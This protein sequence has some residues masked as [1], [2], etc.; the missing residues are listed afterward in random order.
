[1]VSVNSKNDKIKVNVSSA[2]NKSNANAQYPQTY[3]DSMS[4]QWAISDE[5]VNG[6]D[7]SSKHY[8]QEAK[9]N[10]ES[11]DNILTS[12]QEEHE[13][14]NKDVATGR[15]N[16]ANDL[17]TSLANISAKEKS[18]VDTVN[19]AQANAEASIAEKRTNAEN[20]IKQQEE[21]SIGNI[22]S[23]TAT[24][25][26]EIQT[27]GAEQVNLA[28]EQAEISISKTNEIKEISTTTLSNL[29]E[30]Q[31]SVTNSANNASLSEKNAKE[32]ENK[33]S[34]SAS[35]ATASASQALASA[36]TAT[37]N[38]VIATNKAKEASENASSASASSTSA[39]NYAQQ[40]K[41]S[42]ENA[43][44]SA[45]S[46]ST[47]EA[48]ALLYKNSALDSKEKAS[49][50]EKLALN[51]KNSASSSAE[52]ASTK[53]DIATTQANN[54]SKSATNAQTSANNA[55]DYANS[56][57]TSAENAKASQ[58]ACEDILNR[59]G[60]AIKIKG[61]VN[62]LED[63]PATGNLDGDA[64]L[65]GAE[66]L[67]AYPE[68]YWYLNHWEFLGTSNNGGTW[69]TIKGDISEQNDLQSALNAKQNK[70]TFDTTPTANSTKP[71]TSG[72]IKTA[73]DK[74]IDTT[75]ETKY[76]PLLYTKQ[77]I[78]NPTN[79]VAQPYIKLATVTF[80]NTANYDLSQLF[81]LEYQQA[82]TFKAHALVKL[83]ARWGA[84]SYVGQVFEI[85]EDYN[86][87]N[88]NWESILKSLTWAYKFTAK[89][90][91]AGN[92][93][94]GEIWIKIPNITYCAYYLR[95]TECNCYGDYG[96]I[97]VTVTNNP[98]VYI[99]S[100]NQNV[101]SITEGY[102]QV[103]VV[104]KSTYTLK[105]NKAD[106]P[107][108]TSQLINDSNYAT[109]TEAKYTAG[110]GISINNNVIS[111]TQT[112]AEWGNIQGDI[113]SQNDLI[114]LVESIED[115]KAVQNMYTT[116]AVSTDT[117]GYSQ[118]LS[119]KRSTFDKSKFTVVGTPTITDDGV[120]SG[121]S[122]GNKVS[123]PYTIQNTT[124]FTI[125]DS[126]TFPTAI[127]TSKQSVV[128]G[129]AKS[130]S[131]PFLLEYRVISGGVGALL[132]SN[133]ADTHG[134]LQYNL[135]NELPVSPNK[136]YNYT[137]TV[138]GSNITLNIEG[139]VKTANDFYFSPNTSFYVGC[140]R[141][142]NTPFSG[143]IDLSQFSITVDSKEVFSGNKT[144]I[145]TIKADNY[146][147][148]GSPV[149]T[150]DGVASGFSK[151]NKI[152]TDVIQ[153]SNYNNWEILSP[154][155]RVSE[156]SGAKVVLFL[157]R[158]VYYGVRIE[159]SKKVLLIR[160]AS[161]TT[162][163]KDILFLSSF[164]C[165]LNKPY[166]VRIRFTG[167]EYIVD[168]RIVGNDWIEYGRV[169]NSTKIISDLNSCNIGTTGGGDWAFTGSIDLNSFKI[170]VD[171]N[172]VY[173]PC[174]K[175]PY[176]RAGSK[177]K[178]VDV[179]YRDRVQDLYEQEG[180]A[181]YYTIDEEN[182]N[183]TLPMG[184]I[185]GMI[186]QAKSSADG[187]VSKSGDTM[188]GQLKIKCTPIKDGTTPIVLY[189][190]KASDFGNTTYSNITFKNFADETVGLIG[191]VEHP[192]GSHRIRLLRKDG[193]NWVEMPQI[194][195]PYRNGKSGY[196]LYSNG[197]CEQWGYINGSGGG[198]TWYSF[199][200]PFADD[201]FNIDYTIATTEGH[202]RYT[203][204]MSLRAWNNTGFNGANVGGFGAYWCAR[205]YIT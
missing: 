9:K 47:S 123:I 50:S 134:M 153:L 8:A 205:G 108:K 96:Q 85:L 82:S 161:S 120:A 177:N 13:A 33:A 186:E 135:V 173:Q 34:T 45:T 152:K 77:S 124:N 94:T 131:D 104:D 117:Q 86:G 189:Q 196:N 103:K 172:L 165:D 42:A 68:Y 11:A 76:M 7:Y 148:V 97:T 72:G 142:G 199:L 202:T 158:N 141:N 90:D 133:G 74:K 29:K 31:E 144:G 112:S 130:G 197:Y 43:S 66:G 70:L 44:A 109:K 102:T 190:Q 105:A 160:L 113:Q 101:A 115:T 100:N 93:L 35:S 15:E 181:G 140:D 16:I 176:T 12:V 164:T 32:S 185:Y 23:T 46:A 204:Q 67:D 2:N 178:I 79:I 184:E 174:L 129:L 87:G 54:A 5:L 118:L 157:V 163:D 37:S 19:S 52:T 92:T 127:D 89:T 168:T 171:G 28:K 110:T 10:K 80:K 41:T 40:A 99:Y 107:T 201:N 39:N 119:M 59:L 182:Q 63:L 125:K 132:Y 111:N 71:V 155:F 36:E 106:L 116:G 121:F 147:V 4:K 203:G 114:K 75:R 26:N 73:L 200:L 84:T 55:K 38:A 136:T 81:W 83:T 179:A 191:G 91:T 193:S 21:T 24:Q 188:T 138:K 64:Y 1:M 53:A 3:F 95:P 122:S 150:D 139:V 78:L 20:S 48:N 27:E 183:F 194:V 175:I 25:I 51:Y 198:G 143:S 154:V 167:T 169:S 159:L 18:A 170:Y 180:L 126:F 56:A 98:W 30:V 22:T 61:R 137:I 187:K 149:I 156:E 65:V 60:S 145:D 166:Q 14:I 17:E 146:E 195:Y 192:D 88:A 6:E 57:S 69:G 151:D 58:T 62:S 162:S 128:L 49:E